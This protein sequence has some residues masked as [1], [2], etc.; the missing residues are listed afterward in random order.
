MM[1]HRQLVA[2]ERSLRD[3]R[4]LSVYLD[5]TA[6][7]PAVQRAWRVQLDHSLKD[8]RTWLAGSTHLEREEFE[9]CAGLLE[10]QLSRLGPGVGSPGWAAFITRDG[11][12]E[13]EAL[14]VPV[15][16]L[17]V[18]STGMCISPY[19]RALKET[20]SVVVAVVDAREAK[21]LRYRFGE[22]D[23]VEEI[24]AH[25]PSSEPAHMGGAPRQG[26]HTGTRGSTGRDDAQ[27]GLLQGTKRMVADAA[28]RASELAGAEGWI[29]VGGIPRVATQLE[30]DVEPLAT[31]RVL[32]LDSL[33]V[34]SSNEQLAAAARSGASTLRDTV[35]AS[36]IAA[37]AGDDAALGALGPAATRHALE[38]SAV[39][40]LYVTHRFVDDHLSEAE[41][42]VR[43][44]LDQG[45]SVEEVSGRAAE[46]L[47]AHGGLAARLRHRLAETSGDGH[48]A[49]PPQ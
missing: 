7:D 49:S 25:H 20:R 4:V 38:L 21:L 31:K 29:V 12:R 16:T 15:P 32:V 47:D 2:L 37:L 48:E 5:G 27:R 10:D 42:A 18:W 35:D 24:R 3:E 9:Q 45:A 46:L 40:D 13:V 1:T 14:P 36:R 23:R 11:V 44:A 22:I 33:D 17:A 19:I 41:D 39:R 8:L 30:R 26:F 28:E 43:A 6:T 34:H